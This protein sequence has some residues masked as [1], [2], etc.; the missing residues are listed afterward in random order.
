MSSLPKIKV[1]LFP[2]TIPSTKQAAKYRPFLVKEEK[3]LLIAQSGDNKKEMITSLKQIISNCVSL[4]SGKELDVDTLT[5]FD[6]E[7]LFLKIRSKSVDNVA[8]LKYLDH[9]DNKTY[10]FKINLDDIELKENKEHTNKI[11]IGDG[12]T[13]LMKYPTIDMLYDV[14]ANENEVESSYETIKKCMDKIYK[15]DNIINVVDCSKTELD[16][17]VDNLSPKV[18]AEVNKFFLTMPRLYYKIEYTNTNGTE[19]EIE[20]SSLDDFFTLD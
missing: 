9:E 11:T 15:K 12:Y 17:F 20:L 7:Y 16:E 14:D 8:V 2:V 4:N 18:I 6:F 19:R 1:P 5:T 10:E 3:I 13:L